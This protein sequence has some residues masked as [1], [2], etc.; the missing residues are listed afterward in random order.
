MDDDEPARKRARAMTMIALIMDLEEQEDRARAPGMSFKV[1]IDEG[2]LDRFFDAQ[3]RC[4]ADVYVP[5]GLWNT[6]MRKCD[7]AF[8]EVF[9]LSRREFYKL[10]E[11]I[12]PGLP[13]RGRPGGQR[14]H[15]DELHLAVFMV[16][17]GHGVTTRLLGAMFDLGP[18]TNA[19]ATAYRMIDRVTAAVNETLQDNIRFPGR[20]ELRRLGDLGWD[21]FCM[22][23]CVGAIDGTHVKITPSSDLGRTYAYNYKKFYS[24]HV[25]AVAT[26][27]RKFIFANV[28]A[29][30]R[31]H[32]ASVAE[33]CMLARLQ[34]PQDP[35]AR[36]LS[37]PYV[38]LG[39]AAFS[40]CS[41]I[42]KPYAGGNAQHIEFDNQLSAMR[43]IIE[44]AFGAWKQTFRIVDR[45]TRRDRESSKPL[46][47][48]TLYLHNFIVDE[49]TDLVGVPFDD[50]PDEDED[51]EG[52]REA[53]LYEAEHTREKAV[54]YAAR[55]RVFNAYFE[56]RAEE[57]RVELGP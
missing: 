41:W 29:T 17:A 33:N 1:A 35:D 6:M 14:A 3:D 46:T 5:G 56:E 11:I 32:D 21:K 38:L 55:T 13:P 8:R 19:P 43:G 49:R 34:R 27:D 20:E 37:P 30:G 50:L 18:T 42:I 26:L 9:H 39:D 28:G 54:G 31:C 10:L 12:K 2:S 57:G 22:R 24:L 44:M 36:V 52:V 53:L 40:S 4:P 7:R 47:E 51:A 16:Y 25:L 45:G 48:A 23:D 15:S